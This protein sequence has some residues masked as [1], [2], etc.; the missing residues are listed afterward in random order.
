[1]VENKLKL[2]LNEGI[3]KLPDWVVFSLTIGKYLKVH[4]QSQGKPIRMMIS[5]PSNDYIPLLIAI[6]IADGNF[7][8]NEDR[9]AVKEKIMSLQEGHRI[10]YLKMGNR[11]MCPSLR[12]VLVQ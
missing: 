2:H 7:E 9:G 1:M 6:G 10:I 11:R 4:A 5:L 8:L 3:V 12:S